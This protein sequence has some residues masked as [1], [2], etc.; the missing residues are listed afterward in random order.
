MLIRTCRRTTQRRTTR[1]EYDRICVRP[2]TNTLT[3]LSALAHLA[4]CTHLFLSIMRT[5]PRRT[6]ADKTQRH[7]HTHTGEHKSVDASPTHKTRRVRREA[8]LL[9]AAY[10]L[11]EPKATAAATRCASMSKLYKHKVSTHSE[12]AREMR[13][14][15]RLL[16][17]RIKTQICVRVCWHTAQQLLLGGRLKSLCSCTLSFI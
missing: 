17:R 16:R 10:K 6:I 4:S 14:K 13:W 2:E 9:E 3:K 1:M 12:I 5:H 11:A 15:L 7:T 8:I